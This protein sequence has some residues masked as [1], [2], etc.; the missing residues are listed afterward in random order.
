VKDHLDQAHIQLIDHI[1]VAS[2]REICVIPP[3]TEAC[4][5]RSRGMTMTDR[6]PRS[7]VNLVFGYARWTFATFERAGT[8]F[9]VR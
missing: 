6:R 3:F 7:R 9:T 4:L 2:N 8:S 1:R 5:E